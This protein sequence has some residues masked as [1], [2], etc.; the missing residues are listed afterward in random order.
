MC[1]LFSEQPPN[2]DEEMAEVVEELP[3]GSKSPSPQDRSAQCKVLKP[4]Y[5]SNREKN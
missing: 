3:E 2:S 1:C 4:C 5:T